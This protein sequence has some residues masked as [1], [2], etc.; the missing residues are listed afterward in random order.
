MA[1]GS[2]RGVKKTGNR[3]MRF[4][5]GVINPIV[6]Q[7]II[8]II[9]IYQFILI[10]WVIFFGDRWENDDKTMD[11]E[12]IHFIF[13]IYTVLFSPLIVYIPNYSQWILPNYTLILGSKL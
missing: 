7:L 10:L 2:F 12:G 5:L 9:W 6:S 11:L 4:I 13:P 1:S 8:G 3:F